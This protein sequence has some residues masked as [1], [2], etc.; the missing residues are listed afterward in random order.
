M[1]TNHGLF[2]L[3]F[4]EFEVCDFVG[5]VVMG[6]DADDVDA[7]GEGGD[8]EVG[9]IAEG[10]HMATVHIHDQHLDY[11]ICRANDIDFSRG[12]IRHQTRICGAVLNGVRL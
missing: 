7:G 4:D 11:L 3:F 10:G 12:G 2:C 6:L 1:P 8:V 9:G 5:V